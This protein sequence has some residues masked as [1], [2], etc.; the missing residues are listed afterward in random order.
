MKLLYI[1][2]LAEAREGLEGQKG[3]DIQSNPHPLPRAM[4]RGLLQILQI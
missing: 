4:T 1:G 2:D 3:R